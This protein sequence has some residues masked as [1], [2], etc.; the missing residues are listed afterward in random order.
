MSVGEGTPVSATDDAVVEIV[1]PAI[2]VEKTAGASAV[3]QAADGA[4]Y[5]T[6]IFT[7]NVTYSSS[8]R[9]PARRRSSTSP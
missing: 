7:D 8:S 4:T 5:E 9:T 6:E 1:G 3:S 2:D